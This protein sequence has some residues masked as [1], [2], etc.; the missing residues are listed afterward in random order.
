MS[1]APLDPSGLEAARALLESSGLP[2]SDLTAE[3][4]LLGERLEGR[5]VGV[6]GLEVHGTTGLLRS[7]AVET[8]QRGSGLGSELVSAVERLAIETGIRDLYLLTTTAEPFFARRGYRRLP[9]EAAPEGIRKT[10]E[11]SS[12][13]PTSSAFMRK[14]LA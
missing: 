3:V 9:R 8:A 7:L 6:V 2:V 1:V 5:V 13:C 14:V 4:R 10:A 12:I 11:F